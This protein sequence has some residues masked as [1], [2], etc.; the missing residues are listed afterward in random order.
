[1]ID[2]STRYTTL[3]HRTVRILCTDRKDDHYPIVGL[4]TDRDGREVMASWSSDGR[5]FHLADEHVNDLVEVVA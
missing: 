2:M 1:M 5:Y 4:I 3:D